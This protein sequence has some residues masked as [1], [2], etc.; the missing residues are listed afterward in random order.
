V[1]IFNTCTDLISCISA[2]PIDKNN[3]EDVETNGDDH[4]YDAFRYGLMSRPK[5]YNNYEWA[6]QQSE[7]PII[8]N[9]AFGF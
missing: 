2:L 4:A 7:Q 3:P 5:T 9:N 1:Y 8:F 6:S